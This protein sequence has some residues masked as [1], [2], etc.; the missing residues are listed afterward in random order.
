MALPG[1]TDATW[2]RKNSSIAAY[3]H[4]LEPH[5]V[6]AMSDAPVRTIRTDWPD[7]RERLTAVRRAVF[8][9]EQGVPVS[10]ELDDLDAVCRHVLALAGETPIGTGRITP[11]GKIGRL[12]VLPR[13]RGQ[14]VGGALLQELLRVAAEAGLAEVYLHAQVNAL[15]FYEGFGFRASGPRFEEAG[16]AHRKMTRSLG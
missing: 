15:G 1:G 14:G 16:I 6:K 3:R 4:C 7:D 5:Q 13:W 11:T 2:E 8:V 10:I 12:A 9:E